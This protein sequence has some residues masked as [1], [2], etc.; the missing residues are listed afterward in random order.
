MNL[1][2]KYNFQDFELKN[3]FALAP[4]TR[5]KTN[6]TVPSK[7]MAIYYRQRS[8]AGL[9]IT[10]ATQVSLQGQGYE[11]TPGIYTEEQVKAWKEITKEVHSRNS[12][13]FVQ[14]WHVGRVSSSKV[15]GL[16]PL[17]PSS[18]KA[19]DTSVFYYVDN[20]N[21]PTFIDVDT[22]KEMDTKDIQNVI[23]EFKIASKNAM[24][25]D[26]DGVEIHAANGYLFDQY[27]RDVSNKRMDK[28]G[29]SV[30]N[31]ARLLLE[32]VDACIKEIGPEKVG[33]RL[34]PFIK[35][36][37]MEDEGILE[38]ILYVAKELNKRDIAYI[39]LCE[40][41]WEDA[42]AI[43]LEFRQILRSIFKGTIIVAGNKTPEEA[44]E[45]LENGYADIIGF[46]RKFISNPDYPERVESNLALTE[47]RDYSKLFS[48]NKLSGYI[49]YKALT[50]NI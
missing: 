6:E 15:N 2:D 4:M 30:E 17:A 42:P 49:D 19:K 44:N 3:R 29:G 5:A 25:A 8:T 14:L 31:K 40:A 20:N 22:P 27:L 43:P 23:N 21:D 39:H 12:K 7:E 33:V 37:D 13:I 32:T 46:G 24:T 36:K 10:E 35:I 18:I 50:N 26:F 48:R 41:D 45:L 28:Y 34:S 11:N 16:I 9:I 1:F 38:T 47:I